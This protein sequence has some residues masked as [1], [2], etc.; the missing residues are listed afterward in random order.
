VMLNLSKLNWTIVGIVLLLVAILL[1]SYF[2]VNSWRRH[3]S[4]DPLAGLGPGM[5][6]A[7]QTNTGDLLGFPTNAPSKK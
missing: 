3:K 1:G 6:H 5:Y 4:T 2:G 7:N